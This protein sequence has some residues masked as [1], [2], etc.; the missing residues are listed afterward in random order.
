MAMAASTVDKKATKNCPISVR[1]NYL[2]F[3]V[4]NLFFRISKCFCVLLLCSFYI[5]VWFHTGSA[6]L[7]VGPPLLLHRFSS[8]PPP[9]GSPAKNRTGN[10]SCRRKAG[11]LTTKIRHS[12]DL[13]YLRRT[14]NLAMPQKMYVINNLNIYLKVNDTPSYIVISRPLLQG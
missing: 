10:P 11:A 5:G 13:F 9:P 7:S 2:S 4:M 8:A 12:P 14:P 6:P 1:A 3:I